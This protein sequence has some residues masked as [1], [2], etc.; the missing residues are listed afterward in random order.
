[1]RSFQAYCHLGLG[2]LYS[3]TGQ[4][5]TEAGLASGLVELG[6]PKGVIVLA[7]HAPYKQPCTGFAAV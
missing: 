1:M 2:M 6:V 7:F 3:Q 4:L 5:Q